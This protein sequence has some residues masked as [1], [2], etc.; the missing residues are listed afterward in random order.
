MDVYWGLSSVVKNDLLQKTERE[1]IGHISIPASAAVRPDLVYTCTR[2]GQPW[3]HTCWC[4]HVGSFM[5]VRVDVTD[6][7][8]K[9]RSVDMSPATI[10]AIAEVRGA[11]RSRSRRP[12]VL[13][14]LSGVADYKSRPNRCTSAA[15]HGY[16]MHIGQTNSH[17][18][19]RHCCS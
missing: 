8:S 15:C 14:F 2:S 5:S 7:R 16:K 18:C 6:T 19:F 10:S 17:R 13:L 9:G 12:C 3:S 11:G 4:I 1:R